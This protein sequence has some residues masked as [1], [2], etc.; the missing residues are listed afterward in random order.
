ML[1]LHIK[2]KHKFVENAQKLATM[3]FGLGLGLGK[4]NPVHFYNNLSTLNAHRLILS[5]FKCPTFLQPN[6]Y[7]NAIIVQFFIVCGRTLIIWGR[8]L[9][10][11]GL[12]YC[13]RT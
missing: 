1:K 10:A 8:T 4:N 9:I 2:T 5:N 11:C 12:T 7:L 6:I 3:L 13:G